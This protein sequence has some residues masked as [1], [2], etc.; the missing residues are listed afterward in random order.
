VSSPFGPAKDAP[1]KRLALVYLAAGWS[2]IPLPAREKSPVP[3]Q[4][5]SFTGERGVYVTETQAKAWCRANG[6]A[7]A[8]NFIYPPGNIALRLPKGVLGVDVDAHSGKAG[9]ETFAKA[10]TEWGKLPP[11]WVSTS[12]LGSPLSGIRLFRIPEG[13]AWPGELPFGK[14]VELIRWDHRY[15]LVAPSIHDKTG[16]E[17]FWRTPEGETVWL[18]AGLRD[19]AEIELPATEELPWL[20]E[21]WVTGLTSGAERGEAR[22][23]AGADGGQL[24]EDEVRSWLEERDA[25]P[26]S[27]AYPDGT[28]PAMLKTLTGA[29]RDVRKAGDDGGAHDAARDGA[30]ALIGDAHAGH[31]GVQKSLAQLR[32]AFLEAVRGRRGGNK[33]GDRIANGEWKRFVIRGVS[34]VAA[35]GAPSEEDICAALAAGGSPSEPDKGKRVERGAAGGQGSSDPFDYIRDDI[36]NAQ[37]MLRRLSGSVAWVPAL[38]GWYLWDERTGLWRYDE[39]A[40]A[41]AAEAT[42]MVRDMETEAEY[43]ENP[44]AKA[45]FLKFVRGCG[46]VGRLKSMLEVL[47]SMNGVA[48][49]A[50]EFDAG[51][52]IVVC[53][54]G[55]LELGTQRAEPVGFRPLERTDFATL[56]TRVRYVPGATN[57]DFDKYLDRFLPDAEVRA[58]AQK[59]AGYTLFGGNPARVFILAKGPTSSGKTTFVNMLG[60]VLGSYG[61]T[62]SLSLFRDNQ[63]ERPRADIVTALPRRYIFTEETSQAWKLHADQLKRAT[64]AGRW[65][66]RSP[67]AKLYVERVPAF[68]PWVA[69]NNPPTIE[70]ADA[71]LRRRLRVVPFLHRIDPSE[72]DPFFFAKLSEPSALEAIF[73][74]A[75]EGWGLYLDDE[76]LTDVPT[77][78][79]EEALRAANEFSEMDECLAEMCDFEA[80][81]MTPAGDLYAAYQ[82]WHGEN[83]HERDRLSSNAFGRVL[84][85]KGF[86]RG[87]ERI[88][89]DSKPTRVRYGL[90]L[91]DEWR[92]LSFGKG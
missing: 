69:T 73:A 36:G 85:G 7:K 50:S 14:G 72:D 63:D 8:G 90:I 18:G 30:W 15:M 44:K 13:L 24:S 38:G 5:H 35:E 46:N 48:R 55:V 87:V 70:G 6:R 59:L 82:V 32:R 66:A 43:I 92:N 27:G 68:T 71:A 29:L 58:W 31:L 41:L 81:A 11:T 40:I 2:P 78:A 22:A 1:Y 57:E 16:D 39:G 83:G 20:P 79:A 34:K 80:S 77:V 23:L 89:E 19:G 37:R 53:P 12:K 62:F 65:T 33:S 64:G 49:E 10:E 17:Y 28:C 52:R 67:F 60:S 88:G 9:A 54:N 47:K 42:R 25:R 61:G 3:D 75:V 56:T 45:E 74:W 84:S 4:P 91:R 21:T 51:D 86:E 76:T 26:E